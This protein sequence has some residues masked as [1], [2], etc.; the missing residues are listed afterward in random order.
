MAA[1][2]DATLELGDGCVMVRSLSGPEVFVPIFPETAR[3]QDGALHLS[4]EVYLPGDRISVG[5]GEI[6]QVVSE[7]DDRLP[8]P[9]GCPDDAVVWDAR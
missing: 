7:V 6:N 4:G 5:G 8:F 3:W 2:L 9:E 1:L